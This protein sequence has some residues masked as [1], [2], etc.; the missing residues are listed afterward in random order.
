MSFQETSSEEDEE[1]EK[2]DNQGITLYKVI[3]LLRFTYLV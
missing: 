3:Q 2:N 1:A